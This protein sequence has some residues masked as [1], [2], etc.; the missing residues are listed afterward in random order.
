M[1]K[2]P[3]NDLLL[4][5][6]ALGEAPEAAPLSAADEARLQALRDDS[7]QILSRYPAAQQAAEISRLAERARARRRVAYRPLVW[8]P[9]L[10]TAMSLIVWLAWPR[11]PGLP[12]RDDSTTGD[13]VR[14]KGGGNATQPRLVVYRQAATGAEPLSD[15]S[16]A[17]VGDLIQLAYV[18]GSARY[19]VLLSIDGRGGVTMHFPDG[20]QGSTQLPAASGS[21]ARTTEMR[22]PHAFRLDDAPA[23]ERFFFVAAEEPNRDRLN[24]SAV[25]DAARRLAADR[26]KVEKAALPDLPP[27]LFS[28][29]LLVRKDGR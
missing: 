25:L 17:Q 9:T 20:P 1:D 29:S 11:S 23:F 24:P 8:L 12:T 21:A 5:K 19:G 16:A 26:T 22:L 10:A 2:R 18:P 15:G 6:I 7:A 3:A 27:G 13:D 28:T 4:E 14:V